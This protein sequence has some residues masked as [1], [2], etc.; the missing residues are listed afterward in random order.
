MIRDPQFFV[1]QLVVLIFYIPVLWI[2]WNR[3]RQRRA[4]NE[5]YRAVLSIIKRNDNLEDC[6][7]QI[8]IIYKK[9]SERYSYVSDNYRSVTDIMEDLLY[10]LESYSA[11][12]FKETVNV[13]FT[14]EDKE[15]VVN[16]IKEMKRRQPY[17][18]LNSKHGNLLNLLKTSVDNNNKDLAQSTIQQ[19]SDEIEILE[20]TVRSHSKRNQISLVVSAIGVVLTFVFGLITVVQALR[21]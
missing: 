6:I 18:S 8:N 14:D 5:F 3:K 10:R 17:S 7:E 13:E 12:R 11:K 15:K 1:L 2:I 9:N 19:L 21:P 16:I 4:L 20:G